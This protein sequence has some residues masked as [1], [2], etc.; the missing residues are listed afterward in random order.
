LLFA[1]L[2][3]I[4]TNNVGLFSLVFGS[5]GFPFAF[6]MIVVCGAELYTSVCAYGMAAWWEGKI[7]ALA[8]L[9]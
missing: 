2:Q 5:V 6:T 7:S 9:R 4:Q 8:F 1:P 3:D